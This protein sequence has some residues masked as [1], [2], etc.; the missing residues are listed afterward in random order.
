[1]PVRNI[2]KNHISVTGRHATDKSVGNADFE[3]L[4]E[5]DYLILLDFDPL[6]ERYEVQPVRVPVPGVQKGYVPD[7][8]VHF[9]P[10][11]AGK[12]TPSQLTEVKTE[13]DYRKNAA[14]HAPKFAAAKAFAEARGWTFERKSDKHIRTPRLKNLKFLRAY[15]HLEPD[16]VLT[17]H[18]LSTLAAAGG[19]CSSIQLL[20][21]ACDSDERRAEM[22]PVLW[23]LV[24]TGRIA[25]DWNTAFGPDVPL[26]LP[27]IRP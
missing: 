22:L 25:A 21:A 2:P 4:L 27:G 14:D 9:L 17:Q 24:V 12:R 19:R 11:S 15:R 18:L 1:M 26:W 16:P 3:S 8:L 5:N 13:E 20:T 6:V 10:D 23:H 7:V